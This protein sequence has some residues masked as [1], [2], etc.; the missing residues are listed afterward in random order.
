MVEF[1]ETIKNFTRLFSIKLKQKLKKS[2][3]EKGGGK[4]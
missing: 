3:N 4:E 2:K 1:L